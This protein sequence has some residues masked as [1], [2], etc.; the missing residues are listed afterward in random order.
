MMADKFQ[1]THDETFLRRFRTKERV[2][3]HDNDTVDALRKAAKQGDPYAQY[4]YGRWLYYMIPYEDA[5]WD[6]EKLFWD[7]KVLI[8]DALAAYAQMRRYG[9]TQTTSPATMD[10]EECKKLLE[11]AKNRGSE[12][13]ELLMARHRVFGNFREPEPE[14]VAKEIEKRLNIT[15]GQDT[16]P[17]QGYDPSWHTV[18]AFAYEEAGR[19]DDAISQYEQAIALGELEAYPYLAFIYE[20]RGNIALYEEYM[21]EGCEKGSILCYIYQA[22]TKDEVFEELPEEEQQKLHQAIDERL[23]RGLAMG[24]GMCGYYL[25]MHY[26]YEELGYKEDVL[27]AFAYLE[28][29]AQLACSSC[30]LELA[31]EAQSCDLPGKTVT[32]YGKAE[33]WLKAAR[34]A[35]DDENALYYLQRVSDPAFLL[36]YKEELER[37]W[38]P[39]FLKVLGSEEADTSEMDEDD[40]RFD[41][42]A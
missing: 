29:G 13:A 15:S 36:R 12:L 23:R 28:R 18:L 19:D 39:Q 10:V 31:M 20:R 16:S 8:P 4:G 6:A 27:K 7:A 11:Q 9:E 34:Y 32:D 42:W 22:D 5:L 37:Y 30:A 1:I 40:G 38:K 14:Q 41:A 17:L 21:E 35:P 3:H 33:L 24:E 26:Y 2:V 25:W